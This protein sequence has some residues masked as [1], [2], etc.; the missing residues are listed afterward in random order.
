MKFSIKDFLSN[1]TKSARNETVDLVT[2]T[3]E[4]LSGRLW[5]YEVYILAFTKKLY[6]MQNPWSSNDA[7]VY[8]IIIV[9]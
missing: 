1:V 2:F 9:D 3:E 7:V 6:F 4:I 8:E 5:F